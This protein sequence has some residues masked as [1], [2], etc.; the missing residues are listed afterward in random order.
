[1]ESDDRMLISRRLLD[2][3]HRLDELRASAGADAVVPIESLVYDTDLEV[4]PIE[5]LAP[6]PPPPPS[7]LERSF[8]TFDRLV[9]AS[10][11]ATPALAALLSTAG[12][13]KSAP[14]SD[15][16]AVPIGTL[17]YRGQAAL[18][19]ADAV[20][21]QI[22]H[23]LKRDASLQSVQPLLEELLDL[24]PLALAES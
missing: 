12:P 19:R 15:E 23:E 4:V 13:E 9:K 10:A 21:Q 7:G 8:Q 20:R 5:S 18:Q 3:A 6:E 22:V 16:T 14:D 24:V 17:C 11:P 1:V 2:V